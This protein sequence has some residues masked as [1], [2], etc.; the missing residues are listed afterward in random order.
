MEIWTI[1]WAWLSAALAFAILETLVPGFIFLGFAVGAFAVA[2]LLLSMNLTISLPLLLLIFAAFSLVAWL[3]M[4]R[5]FALPGS[6]T[7]TFD[8]DIND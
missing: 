6:E 1:W 7:K 8:H 2:M 5:F 3:L 4:R